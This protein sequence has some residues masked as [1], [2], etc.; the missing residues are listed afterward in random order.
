MSEILIDL[1]NN[2]T[3]LQ[4]VSGPTIPTAVAASIQS[5]ILNIITI[6]N[7]ADLP[8]VAFTEQPDTSVGQKSARDLLVN[9]IL[10]LQ[11]EAIAYLGSE[12]PNLTYNRTTCKRDVA[13]IMEAIAYDQLYGGNSRTVYAGQRY[14]ENAVRQIASS[15]LAATKGAIAYINT[16]AQAI[17]NNVGPAQ[18][19]QNSVNQYQNQTFTGGAAQG[20]TISNLVALISGTTFTITATNSISGITTAST[21]NMTAGMLLTF[22]L[23]SAI[24]VTGFQSKSGSGPYLVTLVVPTWSVQ[25]LPNTSFTVAG[26]ANANYNGNFAVNS[27]TSNTVT[28][29]YPTDPGVYGGG[30]TT[31][32]SYFGGIVG[33]TAYYVI[34]I[35]DAT[36]FKVSSLLGGGAIVLTNTQVTTTATFAGLISANNAPAITPP[37]YSAG[38]PTLVTVY[39]NINSAK[40]SAI[41][42]TITFVNNTYPY[43]NN[44]NAITQITALFKTVTDTLLFSLANRPTVSLVAPTSVLSPNNSAAKLLLANVGFI[45]AEVIGWIRQNY[46]SLNY[47]D[48]DGQIQ[49][50]KDIQLLVEAV[51]YDLTYGGLSGSTTAANQF[52]TSAVV[53]AL[54]VYTSTF[55]PTEKA[56]KVASLSYLQTVSASIIGNNPPS[57]LYQSITPKTATFIS[58]TGSGPYLVTLSTPTRII[59]IPVGEKITVSGNSNTSYNGTF[60]VTASTST[61]TTI[62]YPSDPGAWSIATITTFE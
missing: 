18:V 49:W 27:S 31:I 20:P 22:D 13:Y 37:T 52:W 15:E 36:R 57:A 6:I 25:P 53:N 2:I 28:I 43:I 17:I 10:F 40:T 8:D 46:G 39:G 23:A 16:L 58:K 4:L 54:T 1:E 11:S 7:G 34:E 47:V 33:G 12:W 60:V 14:W 61:S 50:Q 48:A 19:Y 29:A 35:T 62:S 32:T 59:P 42:N 3:A 41:T 38:A 9:N 24:T 44:A 26:N 5:N 45:S 56:A 51:A 55:D 21:T 30:T